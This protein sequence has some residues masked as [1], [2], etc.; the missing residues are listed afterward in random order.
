V[1][2]PQV[3][4]RPTTSQRRPFSVRRLVG[5]P[6]DLTLVFLGGC[7]GGAVRYAVSSSAL[8]D[9]R[10]PWATLA[11]NVA[12]AF[13]VCVAVVL[14]E[15]LTSARRFRL[16]VGIGFCGSL[17][18]FASVVDFVDRSLGHGRPV[19]AVADVALTIL[20]G[21]AAGSF[22]L[23]TGRSIQASRRRVRKEEGKR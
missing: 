12:G 10:F 23:V 13:V 3:I 1:A 9:G 16:F 15:S 18:T 21:L 2:L 20:G 4:R 7:V 11:V 14:A 5:G 17:T 22:G 6:F 19:E 8:A